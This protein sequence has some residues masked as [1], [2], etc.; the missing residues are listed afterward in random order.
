MTLTS[1]I[2]SAILRHE[3][4]SDTFFALLMQ[5]APLGAPVLKMY[6]NH[7]VTIRKETDR[8]YDN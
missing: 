1:D 5:E 4:E 6:D 7:T 2:N 3:Q 8:E